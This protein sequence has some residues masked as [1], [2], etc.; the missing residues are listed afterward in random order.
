M[1]KKIQ[2]QARPRNGR[3][4]KA[5]V[6]AFLAVSALIGL[7]PSRAQAQ[8]PGDYQP[9]FEGMSAGH[10]TVR[11]AQY[12]VFDVIRK[13]AQSRDGL[14]MNLTLRGSSIESETG[15]HV[16]NDMFNAALSLAWKNQSAIGATTIG[17]FVES[18][19]GSYDS[20]NHLR[21]VGEVHGEGD[22]SYLGGGLFFHNEFSTRTY[23]EAS[24]RG[25]RLDN[26]FKARDI[27]GASYD[28]DA[29][30]YGAHFG[31]GQLFY[32]SNCADLDVYG[33][34]LWSHT[35][36]QSFRTGGGERIKFD[37]VDSYRSRLGARLIQC[38][39]DGDVKGY[40]GAAWEYEFDGEAGGRTPV[41]R[42]K[43]KDSPDLKGSSGFAEAGL[44][45]Q[46]VDYDLSVDVGVFGLVGQQKGLGGTVG[47]KYEF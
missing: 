7:T 42:L 27:N 14:N 32:V 20:Y 3:R 34:F 9:F 38:M 30:Y 26:D 31:L 15:S 25:G 29:T 35:E 40:V 22:N 23:I 41:G 8:Q 11:D 46:P 39:D 37:A 5:A 1:L 10:L 4:L 17:A 6:M 33:Q 43:G 36:D 45:I 44:I 28:I 21:T 13:S 18:G 16:E 47:L 12:S 19:A 2:Q 24:V